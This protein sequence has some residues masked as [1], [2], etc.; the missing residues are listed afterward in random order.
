MPYHF[1]HLQTWRVEDFVH[2]RL[3]SMRTSPSMFPS[4]FELLSQY[5]K[6]FF[7]IVNIR[8]TE[9]VPARFAV[10]L[11]QSHRSAYLSFVE[12]VRES[13]IHSD[14]LQPIF[15]P[16]SFIV[17]REHFNYRKLDVAREMSLAF[18]FSLACEA[19]LT[20]MHFTN[21]RKLTVDEFDRMTEV[22]QSNP[23]YFPLALALRTAVTRSEGKSVDKM[24]ELK[25]SDGIQRF[26]CFFWV[27]C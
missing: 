13:W 24:L 2:K 22:L 26:G 25:G 16:D 7:K 5:A 8:T 19:I 6:S 1:S 17:A 20:Y 9:A 15:G 18:R 12:N 3:I 14:E 11:W 23:D 21:K 4:D 27:L 10:Q